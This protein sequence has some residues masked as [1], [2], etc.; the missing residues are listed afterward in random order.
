MRPNERDWIE[1]LIRFKSEIVACPCGNEIFTDDGNSC[2]CDVCG[3]MMKIPY[4]LALRNYSIPAIRGS[5][6]YRCQ[7]GACDEAEALNPVAV[8]LE[9]KDTGAL[10]IKNKSGKQ[11]DA[12]IAKG[13]VKKVASDEIIRLNDGITL[14]CAEAND[15][16]NIL[17][18]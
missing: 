17:A 16:I 3:K 18:N 6:I 7:L 14:I 15:T 5:K 9:K 11:W 10:G 4:K 2:K 13:T 12:V 1:V 8:V